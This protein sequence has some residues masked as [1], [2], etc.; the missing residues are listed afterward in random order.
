MNVVHIDFMCFVIQDRNR[1]DWDTL[2]EKQNKYESKFDLISITFGIYDPFKYLGNVKSDVDANFSYCNASNYAWDKI[3][4]VFSIHF[5]M[6][7]LS[8]QSDGDEC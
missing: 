6:L 4:M 8:T 1:V 5:T 7:F 3:C 2:Y